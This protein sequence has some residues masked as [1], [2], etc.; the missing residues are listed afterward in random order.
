M[1]LQAATWVTFLGL[2]GTA[3]LSSLAS[4]AF[5]VRV[6]RPVLVATAARRTGFAFSPVAASEDVAVALVFEAGAGIMFSFSGSSNLTVFLTV[7]DFVVVPLRA[8]VVFLAGSAAAFGDSSSGWTFFA[9]AVLVALTGSD[10][11]GSG[12]TFL[13][14]RPR[15]ARAGAAVD[16]DSDAGCSSTATFFGRPRVGLVAFMAAGWGSVSSS[17]WSSSSWSMSSDL[18]FLFV[19]V[20][21]VRVALALVAAVTIFV[22]LVEDVSAA[23]AAALALVIRFGGD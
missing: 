10:F 1:S 20:V 3:G 2:R 7:V 19:E 14:G 9:L 21:V 8:L 4:W 23:F 11:A 18:S 13:A 6:E 17:S 15:V 22:V 16:F 12:A 5:V